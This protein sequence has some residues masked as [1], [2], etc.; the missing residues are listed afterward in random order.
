[1][2]TILRGIL[3]TVAAALA[4]TLLTAAVYFISGG[5]TSRGLSD[6]LVYASFATV[7]AATFMGIAK[8]GYKGEIYPD[9]DLLPRLLKEFFKAGSF[10]PALVLGGM[11]CFLLAILVDGLF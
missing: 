5:I 10:P 11:V 2:K 4:V 6:W 3:R 8:F 9:D 1:M 7:T